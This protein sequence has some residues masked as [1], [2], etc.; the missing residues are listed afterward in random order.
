MIAQLL[1]NKVNLRTLGLSNNYI[2]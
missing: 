1:A 2:G